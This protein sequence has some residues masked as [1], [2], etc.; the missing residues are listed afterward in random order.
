MYERIL[1]GIGASRRCTKEPVFSVNN[2][3]A[4]CILGKIIVDVDIAVF[5]VAK[6]VLLILI[7][8]TQRL[9]Q[10]AFEYC[11]GHWLG[12]R[13]RWRLDYRYASPR[14]AL[15]LIRI[16]SFSACTRLVSSRLFPE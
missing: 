12:I 14:N 6:E 8:I 2:E 10:Q 7:E 11:A 16:S 1:A 15:L 9:T 5:R 13:R 4:D 3:W